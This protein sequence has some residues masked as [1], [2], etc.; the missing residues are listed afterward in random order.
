MVRIV[1]PLVLF[2][3]QIVDLK[4]ETVDLDAAKCVLQKE[5]HNMLM[6]LHSSQLQIQAH[7]GVE[8]DSEAIKKKLVSVRLSDLVWTVSTCTLEKFEFLFVFVTCQ[9]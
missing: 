1:L 3:A 2:Q 5:L 9:P 4:Q 6:Q 7:K 8:V